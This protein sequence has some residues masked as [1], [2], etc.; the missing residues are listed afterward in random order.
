M[1]CYLIKGEIMIIRALLQSVFIIVNSIS[2]VTAAH[3]A[4][5]SR[6][7]DNI[8][9]FKIEI[10]DTHG[11]KR[12]FDCS[13]YSVENMNEENKRS[14]FTFKRDLE[15]AQRVISNE[16]VLENYSHSAASE[17]F[18]IQEAI[19]RKNNFKIQ[20]KQRY[21]DENY[22]SI[23]WMIYEC[24]TDERTLFAQLGM[25]SNKQQN[26]EG[27]E[28]KHIVCFG[29]NPLSHY[30]E[31]GYQALIMKEIFAYLR[32]FD[33]FKDVVF[34]FQTRDDNKPAC[35]MAKEL[36]FI[37]HG[38]TVWNVRVNFTD[39]SQDMLFFIEDNHE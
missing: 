1:W 13:R 9:S 3:K 21:P 35:M 33:Q 26:P 14:F 34:A 20:L 19:D 27:Y 22:V 30:K 31:N 36:G 37:Q 39:Q 4:S 12:S 6:K 2:V 10:C 5:V 17:D 16:K 32:D 24:S 28:S 7:C 23:A 8:G 18:I 25:S 38:K 11:K 29:I 15:A